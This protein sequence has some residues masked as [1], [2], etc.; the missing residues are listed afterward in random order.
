[1]LQKQDYA[2]SAFDPLKSLESRGSLGRFHRVLVGGSKILIMRGCKRLLYGRVQRH[3]G[4]CA[5]E[6]S[7]QRG[8]I[9][10]E[11]LPADTEYIAS[12]HVVAD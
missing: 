6:I 10:G 5:E 4:I 9:K 7:G 12:Y 2:A 3:A 11:I 1:M 8:I